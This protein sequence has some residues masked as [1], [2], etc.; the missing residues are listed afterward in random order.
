[1]NDMEA[2]PSA[3]QPRA[4]E[5]PANP[6]AREGNREHVCRACWGWCSTECGCDSPEDD[7]P[8][9]ECDCPWPVARKPGAQAANPTAQEHIDAIRGLHKAAA[10]P[11]ACVCGALIRKRYGSATGWVHIGGQNPGRKHSAEPT[12]R[13]PRVQAAI[14]VAPGP[15]VAEAEELARNSAAAHEPPPF[16]FEDLRSYKRKPGAKA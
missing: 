6:A 14:P 15:G 4:A 13:K 1:M 2:H 7:G 3:A 9:D 16:G 5:R 11:A 12:T 8:C 10:N